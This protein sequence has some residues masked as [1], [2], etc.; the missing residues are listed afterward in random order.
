MFSLGGFRGYRQAKE[1]RKHQQ[2]Q[3]QGGKRGT[4]C[5]YYLN[6]ITGLKDLVTPSHFNL[7]LPA[8]HQILLRLSKLCVQ[9]GLS[10]RKS[11]KQQQR[12]LRNMGAH[13]V[14]LELLQIPYEKVSSAFKRML[15]TDRHPCV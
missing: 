4:D 13:A 11:R 8:L 15:S 5:I 1:S 12:L 2:L 6:S 14:V 9:E 7:F 10:G 3:L